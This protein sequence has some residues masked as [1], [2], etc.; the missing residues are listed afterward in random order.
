MGGAI[1][2]LLPDA[3]QAVRPLSGVLGAWPPS[4]AGLITHAGNGR[5]CSLGSIPLGLSRIVTTFGGNV[6]PPATSHRAAK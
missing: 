5:H 1:T 2:S 3:A 6:V 4:T